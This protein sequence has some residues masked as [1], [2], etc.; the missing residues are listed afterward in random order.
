[1]H[2]R[3]EICTLD[4]HSYLEHEAIDLFLSFYNRQIYNGSRA[5]IKVIHGYGSSGEGGIIR[6]KL[7]A[8]LEANPN[9]VSFD[10]GEKIDGN[11]GYTLVYPLQILPTQLDIL[12]MEILSYCTSL[13]SEEKIAGKFRKFG[14]VAV[15]NSLKNLERQ[16]RISIQWKGKYKC[17]RTVK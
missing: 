3:S 9:L 1:M 10:P 6:N 8:L 5:T 4:L 7:R 15:R 17:Y 13:R 16:G 2:L 11:P 14:D 12:S